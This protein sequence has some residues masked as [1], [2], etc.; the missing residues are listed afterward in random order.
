MLAHKLLKMKFKH[1]FFIAFLIVQL[2]QVF[3]QTDSTRFFKTTQGALI[4]DPYFSIGTEYSW[5]GETKNGFA[6]G[7]GT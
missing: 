2:N 5:D 4:Y 1:I 7:E 3:G 6:E